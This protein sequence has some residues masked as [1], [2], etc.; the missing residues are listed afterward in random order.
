MPFNIE[1][2]SL[3][4]T[5]HIAY[6]D[7]S[8]FNRGRFRSIAMVS[9]LASIVD[10]CHSE[11]EKLIRESDIREFK[12]NKVNDAQMRWAGKK[13]IDF[14]IPLLFT[15]KIRVDVLIW[16][17]LDRRHNVQ[18]RDDGANLERMYYH[19]FKHVLTEKWINGACWILHPDEHSAIDWM[20]IQNFLDAKDTSVQFRGDLLETAMLL[21]EHYKVKII[22]E[23][24][25]I[26]RPLVQL[27]DLFAGMGQHSWND[28]A[29]YCIWQ[30]RN[31]EQQCFEEIVSAEVLS[32][33]K[34]E[35]W[36]LIDYLK[37]KCDKN[38]WGVSLKSSSGLR[39]PGHSD[40]QR[41]INFWLYN[42][43][44]QDDKA[45]VR[46]RLKQG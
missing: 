32:N 44:H 24:K 41:P 22:K 26:E 5:T 6:S 33:K 36:Y 8:N 28:Y 37:K 18:G 16:D 11:L 2:T 17:T 43:Q 46:Q 15:E 45:P 42:S 35:Q 39:T 27:A 30:V 7:E 3:Q 12:W 20:T 31:S 14:S 19:L 38:R 9:L 21:K 10:E 23:C 34:N 13:L 4:D 40:C 29:S 1:N 25:S